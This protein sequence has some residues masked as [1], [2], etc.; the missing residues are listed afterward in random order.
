MG[1]CFSILFL[2]HQ[3]RDKRILLLGLGDAGKTTI[4]EKLRS[5]KVVE[6]APTVG[7]SVEHIKFQSVKMVVWDLGEQDHLR[8]LW[9]CCYQQSDGMIFV[10]DASDRESFRETCVVFDR[11][12]N[13]DLLKGVPLLILINK[14]NLP[15]SRS[16]EEIADALKIQSLHDR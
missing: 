2:Y 14:S 7:I 3:T 11:V 13:D 16:E 15:T 5:D 10:I 1:L 6:T 9:H 12:I 8:K 4:L